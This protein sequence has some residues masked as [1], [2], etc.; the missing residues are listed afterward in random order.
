MKIQQLTIEGMSCGH[1]ITAVKHQLGKLANVKVEDVQIGN[2]K[3]QIDESNVTTE[4]LSK[5]VED[6]GYKLV[7]VN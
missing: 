1:C 6:A 2:A 7:A 3:V 5:A 4:Q